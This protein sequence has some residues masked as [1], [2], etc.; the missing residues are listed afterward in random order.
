MSELST[1]DVPA[2]KYVDSPALP[3]PIKLDTTTR[4]LPGAELISLAGQALE[5][6]D[7]IAAMFE[8]C[9]EDLS[10]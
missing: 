6:M 7:D 5:F 2:A 3:L 1:I 10:D 8:C 9:S 4:D